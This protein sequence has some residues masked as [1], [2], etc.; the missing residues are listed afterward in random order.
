MPQNSL[1]EPLSP[2]SSSQTPLEHAILIVSSSSFKVMHIIFDFEADW[3]FP[4]KLILHRD[5]QDGFLLA[6]LVTGAKD[7]FTGHQK[8]PTLQGAFD[9]T[10]SWTGLNLATSAL[11]LRKSNLNPQCSLSDYLHS[12][13]IIRQGEVMDA[14]VVRGP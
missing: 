2:D 12:L 13:E 9:S 4:R 1:K 3:G 7:I 6:V 14:V 10:L 5:A 8:H 11:W